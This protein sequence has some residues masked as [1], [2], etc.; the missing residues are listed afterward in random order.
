MVRR[1]QCKVIPLFRRFA[2]REYFSFS[3]APGCSSNAASLWLRLVHS[4][5][6]TLGDKLSNWVEAVVQTDVIGIIK[7]VVVSV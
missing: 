1:A 4:A 3:F 5:D 7:A 6:R 2:H